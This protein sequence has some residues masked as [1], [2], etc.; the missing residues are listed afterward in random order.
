V[1]VFCVLAVGFQ[2]QIRCPCAKN[3]SSSKAYA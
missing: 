2:C 3:C 1:I